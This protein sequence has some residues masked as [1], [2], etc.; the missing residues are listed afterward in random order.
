MHHVALVLQVY[1]GEGSSVNAL[2]D[3][4]TSFKLPDKL[5]QGEGTLIMVISDTAEG[6]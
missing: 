4:F 2:G 5:G 1:R 3:S 6:L